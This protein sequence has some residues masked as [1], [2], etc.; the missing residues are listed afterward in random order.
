MPLL[1]HCCCWQTLWSN[2]HRIPGKTQLHAAEQASVQDGESSRANSRTLTGNVSNKKLYL[3]VLSVVAA[4]RFN[5]RF[6]WCSKAKFNDPIFPIRD[7]FG[8]AKSHQKRTHNAAFQNTHLNVT[9]RCHRHSDQFQ[10]SGGRWTVRRTTGELANWRTV[11]H[12][13]FTPHSCPSKAGGN[14]QGLLQSKF[15]CCIRTYPFFYS[16]RCK[17]DTFFLAPD[18]AILKRSER[19]GTSGISKKNW[20]TSCTQ[21]VKGL[22]FYEMYVIHFILINTVVAVS[23]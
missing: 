16:L 20:F 17:R 14:T 2:R 1:S 4:N 5:F 13:R 15:H 10:S 7:I 18:G 21:P 23:H 6:I 9:R 3:D 22:D 11:I 12:W 8:S 19:G